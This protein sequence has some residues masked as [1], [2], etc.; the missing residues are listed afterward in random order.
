MLL[1][2]AL[3]VL[4]LSWPQAL[5]AQR[6]LGIAQ[7]ISFRT[8]LAIGLAV[9]ALLAGATALLRRRH[10]PVVAWGLALILAAGAITNGA[11]LLTRGLGSEA[12]PEGDLVVMAWNTQGGATSPADIAKVALE[13]GADVVSLP[14]TDERAATEV[15]RLLA[16]SGVKM[17]PE[18]VRSG[19]GN[20]RMPTSVLIADRLGEYELDDATGSTPGLPS[21]VWQ[22]ITG[23]GPATIVA[24]HTMPPLPTRMAVWEAGL[25]WIAEVCTAEDIIV[26]GDL[27]ATVDHMAG[28]GAAGHLIGQ[29]NDAA[30]ESG[31]GA[32]GTWPSD[33]PSWISSPIDHVL[34]GATWNAEGT[35]VM[36]A[37]EGS[38]HRSVVA[39]LSRSD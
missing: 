17:T 38:D 34:V 26:A 30:L 19:N 11:V 5:G 31:S 32:G 23:D 15:A 36:D 9:F 27:N 20:D 10:R 2:A 3:L 35:R 13:V 21:G 12:L 4:L 7:L 24:A 22:K 25:E 16:L 18:T 14:E 8:P 33:M 28:L 6:V 1:A 37:L 39:V 29:C